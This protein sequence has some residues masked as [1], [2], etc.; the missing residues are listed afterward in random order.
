[1]YI[2][3]YINNTQIKKHRLEW[4]LNPRQEHFQCYTLPLSYPGKAYIPPSIKINKILCEFEFKLGEL[5][6]LFFLLRRDRIRTCG[7]R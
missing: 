5:N 1:M 4:E 6:D 2:V 3:Y 7:K